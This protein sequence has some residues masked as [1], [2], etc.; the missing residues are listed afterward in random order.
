MN[1]IYL[2]ESGT[3]YQVKEGLFID[4]PF[5]IMGAMLISEDVYWNMERLF[6]KII[7]KFFG[8]D[9]WMNHEIHA[10]DIWFGNPLSS[11]LSIDEK[12]DFFDEFMQLCGKFGLP[13]VFSFIPKKPNQDIEAKN[14]NLMKAAFCL[15]TGIEHRL[16]NIHQT[17]ILICDSSSRTDHMSIS[18]ITS[19]DIKKTHLTPA[20]A[21]LRQFHDM[22]SW[23]TTGS[24]LL[25]II[26]PKYKM[27][28]MSAYIIDCI[29]FS[30]SNDS[31]FLQICD[32]MTFVVQ[33][34]LAYEYLLVV[35]KGKAQLEKLPV[36]RSGWSM[37]RYQIYPTFYHQNDVV[38][39]DE[40]V[41]QSY[42][43]LDFNLLPSMFSQIE[44][45]YNQL[46]SS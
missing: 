3:N 27:E 31:L 42:W 4:G 10:T 44:E 24:Q 34:I 18:D 45:Q 2:D 11:S 13:Y 41:I 25:P 6:T 16:A 29:H 43:C 5:I 21:L 35:D 36:T 9:N 37:M 46:K 22:T 8:I 12:R 7:D 33:R 14:L 15:F 30:N 19:L 39:C 1:L 23:R 32:I 38:A 40:E 17:G 20:Q 28:A 26:R